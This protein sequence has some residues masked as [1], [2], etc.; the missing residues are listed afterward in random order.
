MSSIDELAR[1]ILSYLESH[2]DA[3]DT[4]DG[5]ID[6]WSQEPNI[7]N[8]TASVKDIL[9]ELCSRGL[10]VMGLGKDRR[11]YY[12]INRHKLKQISSCLKQ[13]NKDSSR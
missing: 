13:K 5:I 6:W 3:Q 11:S 12:Q 10:I 1:D 7:R 4:L 2:P 9:N 8:Q